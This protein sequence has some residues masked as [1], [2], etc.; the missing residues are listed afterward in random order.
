MKKRKRSVLSRVIS[1]VLGFL[2]ALVLGALFYATMVYQLTGEGAETART[3]LATPAPLAPQS[4]A[5]ALFPGA[6]LALPGEL[7]TETARDEVRGGEVCRVITRTYLVEGVEATAVSA[8]PSAYLAYLSDEGFS[9][10]LMTGFS[11]DGLDA[12]WEQAGERGALVARD[13]ECVY[14]LIAQ[15]QEQTLYALGTAAALTAAE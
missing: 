2:C 6:L 15:T 3:A 4:D 14:L 13:G 12:V 10:Q 1:A 7:Q 8:T 9:P 5:Q 11:L